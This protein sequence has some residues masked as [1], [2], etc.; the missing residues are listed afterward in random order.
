MKKKIGNFLNIFVILLFSSC[1][2]LKLGNERDPWNEKYIHFS[3]KYELVFRHLEKDAVIVETFEIP[4][5]VQDRSRRGYFAVIEKDRAVFRAMREPDCRVEF[6]QIDAG[7]MLD[8]F[9]HGTGEDDG[10]YRQV[11][12]N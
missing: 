7:V 4:R 5:A 1:S 11:N 10:L 6:R 8:D 9:C 3:G 2:T 12:K